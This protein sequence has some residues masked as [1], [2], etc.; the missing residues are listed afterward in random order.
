MKK[1]LCITL[2]P[3]LDMTVMVD[4]LSLG[5]VNR[6]TG[7]QIDAAGKALNAAQ[8]LSQLGVQGVASGFLGADN[9]GEFDKLFTK[10]HTNI[11]SSDEH[12]PTLLVDEFV[13][14]AGQTRTNIKLTDN[15]TTTDINGKGFVVQDDDKAALMAKVLTLAAHCDAVL[16]AGSLPQ[17]FDGR[18]FDTLLGE[19][20]KV[21]PK[22]AVD[23]SG[24]ALK[25][26]MRHS[27]WLIKPN[28]DE[29]FEAFAKP[30]D[31]LD[32]QQA[33]FATLATDIEHIVISMGDKGVHWLTA[34]QV[35]R[36]TPPA[37]QVKSTVGAGD[38]LVAG[39][40]YGLLSE[41]SPREIL[42]TAVALSAHAVS[43]VGFDVADPVRL[44]ALKSQVAFYG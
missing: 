43:I 20:V 1:V 24:D 36:A 31:T 17:G 25:I 2:N 38:T 28:N 42:A 11:K 41:H 23:V 7:V 8:I 30:C 19:L 34:N 13:R 5:N 32:E 40:I 16:I 12:L 26:A 4:C 14:V 15:G 22:V 39:M 21:N 6:A 37:V 9:V 10:S 29:L 44:D 3:A 33:L 27:L 35:Y 18:D